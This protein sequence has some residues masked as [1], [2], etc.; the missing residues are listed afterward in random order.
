MFYRLADFS[1]RGPTAD[2]QLAPD[3]C[4]P[5]VKIYAAGYGSTG[6]PRTGY[7]E[8]SGTSMAC[9]HAAGA[10]ALVLARHPEFT[11]SEVRSALMS[12]ANYINVLDFDGTPGQPLEIGA[13]RIDLA[14]AMDP[15]LYLEPQS[16]SFSLVSMDAPAGSVKKTF[17]VTSYVNESMTLAVRAVHHTGKGTIGN[18]PSWVRVE[19]ST[20]TI[21]AD[22]GPVN[23][24]VFVDAANGVV[25]DEQGFVLIED[26]ISGVEVAHIPYWARVTFK[27]KDRVD[28]YVIDVDLSSCDLG[29]EATDYLPKYTSA[30]SSA[31]LSYKVWELCDE[32]TDPMP[33][34]I[35]A[36]KSRTVLLFTGDFT[37]D[38]SGRDGEIREIMHSGVPVFQMGAEVGYSWGLDDSEYTGESPNIKNEFS[39]IFAIG[40]STIKKVKAAK[41]APPAFSS[42]SSSAN[43]VTRPLI[44][45]TGNKVFLMRDKDDNVT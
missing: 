43:C 44:G 14:R 9:P 4:A 39:G 41:D 24:T 8:V 3:V 31:G 19:P 28:V 12:T 30:L 2:M 36:L 29:E 16:L 38:L 10:S 1:S 20:L 37:V 42:V 17:T 5:G 34:E 27:E 7:G 15:A 25:G 23:V 6:D 35:L 13:G 22:S 32:N 21:S 33:T 45:D 18:A 40:F 11:P 26:S